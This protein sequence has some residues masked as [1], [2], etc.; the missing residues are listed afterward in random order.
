M[1]STTESGRECFTACKVTQ[2]TLAPNLLATS[3]VL[4]KNWWRLKNWWWPSKN[5]WH[6]VNSVTQVMVL[7][8]PP[9]PLAIVPE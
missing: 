8:P 2:V 4:L 5:T 7:T 9:T 1:G 6:Q 3:L